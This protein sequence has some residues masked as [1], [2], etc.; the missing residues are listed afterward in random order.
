MTYRRRHHRLRPRCGVCHR[1]VVYTRYTGQIHVTNVVDDADHRSLRPI[2]TT[3][4]L[5]WVC[6]VC[7][8]EVFRVFPG[9][10]WVHASTARDLTGHHATWDF[11]RGFGLTSDEPTTGQGSS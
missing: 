6:E 2:L 9:R 4:R 10:R 3:P 8:D 11:E 1:L 5:D 7:G